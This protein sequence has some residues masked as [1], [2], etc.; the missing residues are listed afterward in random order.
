M[1]KEFQTPLNYVDRS[2]GM[3]SAVSD[4]LMPDNACRLSVNFR[5][6]TKRGAAVLREG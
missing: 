1:A 2:G 4:D 5:Y 6:G 3:M